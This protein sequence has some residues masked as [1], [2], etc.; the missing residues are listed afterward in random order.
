M[1]ADENPGV[2]YD[3]ELFARE[4]LPKLASVKLREIVEATGLSKGYA[5]TVRSGKYSPHVSTWAALT[6]L[7]GVKLANR[8]AAGCHN[9]AREVLQ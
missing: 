4:I 3:P 7:V 8:V 9:D 1:G 5:S 2:L 6:E